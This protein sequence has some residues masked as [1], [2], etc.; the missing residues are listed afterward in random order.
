[1]FAVS[2][3][4]RQLRS[5]LYG[6]AVWG[7]SLVRDLGFV[8]MSLG[9]VFL[10]DSVVFSSTSLVQAGFLRMGGPRDPGYTWAL[11]GNVGIS[12]LIRFG[13]W[14]SVFFGEG[15]GKG[16]DHVM[17]SLRSSMSIYIYTHTC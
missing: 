8:R 1:M 16:G 9:E 12:A 6:A 7:V 17:R 11:C 13:L 5:R 14:G 15:G 2:F 4:R 10:R 3:L